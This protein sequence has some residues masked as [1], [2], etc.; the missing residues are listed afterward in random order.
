MSRYL[1]NECCF[2]K[3]SKYNKEDMKNSEVTKNSL[4]SS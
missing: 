4:I 3:D 1:E 2:F